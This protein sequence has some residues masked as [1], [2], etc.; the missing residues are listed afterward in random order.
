MQGL[1]DRDFKFYCPY[2]CTDY[3][4]RMNEAASLDIILCLVCG[5]SFPLLPLTGSS[6]LIACHNHLHRIK[7]S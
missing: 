6:V 7:E 2:C 1:L 4:Y 5:K 3:Y